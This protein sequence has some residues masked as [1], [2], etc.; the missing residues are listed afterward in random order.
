MCETRLYRGQCKE[1]HEKLLVPTAMRME[2]ELYKEYE[3]IIP[4][5][6]DFTAKAVPS[7]YY[8]YF[9]MKDINSFRSYFLS[10]L[11]LCIKLKQNPEF[12]RFCHAEFFKKALNASDTE[13]VRECYI[14]ASSFF[15]DQSNIP[16][17]GAAAMHHSFIKEELSAF[18]HLNH[19]FSKT[20]QKIP[21]PT[22][23]LDWTICPNIATS[24]GNDVFSID[25]EK[26]FSMLRSGLIV[27]LNETENARDQR[28][29][30]SEMYNSGVP[31][32]S[33][34]PGIKEN[35]IGIFTYEDENSNQLMIDQKGVTV[36]WPFQYTPVELEEQNKKREGLGCELDFKVESART[37]K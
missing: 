29:R 21:F 31:A 16:N 6:Y 37:E 32:E 30:A 35:I 8:K 18:Q 36:F 4:S 15:T 33:L 5:H 24:F 22:M 10:L 20:K 23:M 11:N 2:S 7:R 12:R 26:L 34:P 27:K 25:K 1:H 19:V 17:K 28:N 13:T 14:Y 9:N 3:N